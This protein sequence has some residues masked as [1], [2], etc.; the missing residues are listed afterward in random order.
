MDPG[1]GNGRTPT[2]GASV[3]KPTPSPAPEVN[4]SEPPTKKP[5]LKLSV[6]KPSPEGQS[7][8]P[9]TIAVSRPRRT[10]S[11]RVAYSEN[12]NVDEADAEASDVASIHKRRAVSAASTASSDLT[13]LSS[14]QTSEKPSAPA[15]EKNKVR[16][17]PRDYGKDFFSYY[18]AG[19]GDDK[20]DED[21]DDEVKIV[22]PPPTKHVSQAVPPPPAKSVPPPQVPPRQ[23]P[24]SNHM[25]PPPVP[26]TSQQVWPPVER[27]RNHT[28]PPPP[29]PTSAREKP[30]PRPP[31]PPPAPPV[32]VLIDDTPKSSVARP[33]PH[34]RDM[35]RKLEML[36]HALAGF[37]A[38]PIP[39][40]PMGQAPSQQAQTQPFP[41]PAQGIIAQPPPEKAVS[42]GRG[43]DEN[44]QSAADDLLAM[45]DD[46]ENDS[47]DGNAQASHPQPP[48]E[49]AKETNAALDHILES[50]G[51]N[52]HALSYG[53]KFIQNALKSWAHQRLSAQHSQYYWQAHNTAR[54]QLQP[55]KRGP[56]RP[57]K[58]DDDELVFDPPPAR[59]EVPLSKTV[60]GSAIAAFQDV[61]D[62]NCLQVNAILPTELGRALRILYRQIDQLINQGSR[63]DPHWHCMSYDAQII[64]HRLR[65]EEWSAAR[66]RAAVEAQRQQS[67]A[68]QAV[69][70]QMG[71]SPVGS[72]FVYDQAQR[73]RTLELERRRNAQQ[74]VQQPHLSGSIANPISLA[75]QVT[76]RAAANNIGAVQ[77][78][79]VTSEAARGMSGPSSIPAS[80]PSSTPM[81]S[82]PSIPEGLSAD[83]LKSLASNLFSRS[84][85]SMK[86]SFAP[87]SD[88]ALKAFGPQA[89]PSNRSGPSLPNRG[90]MKPAPAPAT[91]TISTSS[92][93]TQAPAP[94]PQVSKPPALTRESSDTIQVASRPSSWQTAQPPPTHF[95]SQNNPNSNPKNQTV[96]YGIN[97]AAGPKSS[98]SKSQSA[99]SPTSDFVGLSNKG[100]APDTLPRPGVTVKQ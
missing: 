85:Q 53:I 47:S 28:G 34:I 93:P 31:L 19:G 68:E 60:E 80:A 88:L 55:Q 38:V 39:D 84:G 33:V 83:K 92:S 67:L 87:N 89:F 17:G 54:Q 91:P 41:P 78:N 27:F 70:Q 97:D 65:V 71:I 15:V 59:Y 40:R 95:T 64:A 36:S 94:Q 29:Y 69:H 7:L 42:S 23:V 72:M 4:A 30:M 58:F 1:I 24:L 26:Q 77:V 76:A 46:D 6:R 14:I 35:I 16:K 86:F 5:R 10:S 32:V 43:T 50:P 63:S 18:V 90:P 51:R 99:S 66:S 9:D 3:A 48:V 45:F 12:M 98:T 25:A 8:S 79:G 75:E 44:G 49:Q 37:G 21:S 57:R 62:S 56:G 82:S 22:A 96:E 81:P 74:A 13:S 52:D 11:L 73:D 20:S 100:I 2:P 61:L